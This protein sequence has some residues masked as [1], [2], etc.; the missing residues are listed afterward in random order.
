MFSKQTSKALNYSLYNFTKIS[1]TPKITL[2]RLTLLIN[3][4][5]IKY[6]IYTYQ[7]NKILTIFSNEIQLNDPENLFQALNHCEKKH[8]IKTMK[9]EINNLIK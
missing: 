7:D 6:A 1:K 3:L 2:S 9:K 5:Q 8:W 4:R